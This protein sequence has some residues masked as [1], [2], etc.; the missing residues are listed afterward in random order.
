[1][2]NT[3]STLSIVVASVV[4]ACWWIFAFLFLLRK[5]PPKAKQQKRNRAS[6]FGVALVGAGYAIVWSIRRPIFTP[7]YVLGPLMDW[8][9]AIVAILLST[10]SVWFI[11]S[12][13][14]ELGRQWNITAQLVDDHKLVT[15]GVYSIVR[16]PIY[17]GMLG[18]MISTGLAFSI[19]EWAAI[20]MFIAWYGTHLRIQSEEALLKEAFGEEY[21]EYARKV[22]ALIPGIPWI[23]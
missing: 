2:S 22:P 6:L 14:R 13:V 4:M 5:K 1:M 8:V 3:T 10:G 16:N 19:P 18:M 7:M 21:E 12:A 9:I 23:N 11:L 15:C 20:A 17:A